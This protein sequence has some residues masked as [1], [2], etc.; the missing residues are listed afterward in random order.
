MANFNLSI[1]LTKLFGANRVTTKSGQEV[2]V[3]PIDSNPITI[4]KNGTAY[5]SL[6]AK[7]KKQVD[8]WGGTHY[9]KPKYKKEGY[10]NLSDE[11]KQ[12]IPFVGTCY[13]QQNNYPSNGGSYN[14]AT[15]FTQ[16][17]VDID[18]SIF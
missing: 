6:E 2:I 1:E 13:A 15:P 12:N 11:Q 18:D 8:Q 3:I 14:N 9:I 17:K 16:P 10:A 7:E 4:G 5:L